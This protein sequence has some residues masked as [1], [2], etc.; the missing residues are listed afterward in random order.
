LR[1][2]GTWGVEPANWFEN[3]GGD[4]RNACHVQRLQSMAVVAV[5]PLTVS[6][7]TILGLYGSGVCSSGK[8]ARQSFSRYRSSCD[9]EQLARVD[10]LG[11][12][13]GLRQPNAQYLTSRLVVRGGN[14]PASH[15]SAA[16]ER[17]VSLLRALH[18]QTVL[19]FNQ[20]LR[21][22]AK[23]WREVCDKFSV[24]FSSSFA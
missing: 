12:C 18:R 13:H 23:R 15:R 20:S 4:K 6:S 22:T 17:L 3:L 11:A 19:T 9:V 5:L 7:E 24:F 14:T 1:S 16:I 10:L 21:H 2:A 8:N